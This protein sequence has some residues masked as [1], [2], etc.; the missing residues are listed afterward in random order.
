MSFRDAKLRGKDGENSKVAPNLELSAPAEGA[1]N[2]FHHF[3][4]TALEEG[5]DNHQIVLIDET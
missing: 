5:S 3:E 2:I 4:D 1:T